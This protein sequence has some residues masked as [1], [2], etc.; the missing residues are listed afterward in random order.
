MDELQN[1]KN[2][3]IVNATLHKSNTR[4]FGRGG[5]LAW[6]KQ[7][8]IEVLVYIES[9]TLLVQWGCRILFDWYCLSTYHRNVSSRF[10]HWTRKVSGTLKNARFQG[11]LNLQLLK[12]LKVV[13]KLQIYI[14]YTFPLR[15][16][17]VVC[18]KVTRTALV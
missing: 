3:R 6:Y 1:P 10:G 18:V 17:G 4:N 2:I 5:L 15:T 8:Y 13:I 11:Y 9:P 7:I 16:D 12:S 14:I